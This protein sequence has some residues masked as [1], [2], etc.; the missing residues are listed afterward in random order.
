MNRKPPHDIFTDLGALRIDPSDPTLVPKPSASRP[1]KKYFVRVPGSWVHR[2]QPVKRVVTY[3]LALF[4][5]YEHWR[6]GG[7]PIRL[8]GTVAAKL[9]ISR[10]GKKRAL[11]EL[12]RLGLVMVERHPRKAPLVTPLVDPN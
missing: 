11:T 5:L 10:D 3:Q 9:G 1:K 6:S 12:E 2:L 7:C 4:L 8:T